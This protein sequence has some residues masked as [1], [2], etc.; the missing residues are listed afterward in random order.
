MQIF[1]RLLNRAILSHLLVAVP[2]AVVLGQMVISI[3][4]SAL[5][6]ETQRLHLSLAAQVRDAIEEEADGSIALLGH[7]ERILDLSET[8]IVQRQDMLRAL[9][10]DGRIPYLTLYRPD[11][12]FDT[13][14]RPKDGPEV[15]RSSLPQDRQDS[16]KDELVAVWDRPARTMVIVP[17]ERDGDL[18]GFVATELPRT[19]LRQLCEALAERHLGTSG[20][21]DVVAIDG[22]Y[23]ASSDP[24]H[25]GLP[26]RATTVF[27][28]VHVKGQGGLTALMAGV[29]GDFKDP[30]GASQLGAVVSSPRLGWLVGASRP[31]SKALASLGRV[32]TRVVLMS[33]IAAL[34]A[35]LVGLLMARQ[36]T[37]PVQALVQSVRRAAQRGFAPDTQIR[38]TGEL[39]QLALAFNQALAQ[40]A[41]Y[42]RQVRQTMQLRLRLSRLATTGSSSARELL[43]RATTAVS[44][45]AAEPMTILYADVMFEESEAAESEYLVTIL[46][47]FFTAAHEAIRQ[48]GGR[49]DRYSGDAVI[50]LFPN[51]S[52]DASVAVAL[53]AAATIRHDAQAI[54]GRWAALSPLRL[55]AS[56]GV[57]SGEAVLV[58]ADEPGQDPTAHGELVE[59]AATLQRR[60]SAGR[61]LLDEPSAKTLDALPESAPEP[62]EPAYVWA[63]TDLG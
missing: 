56:V 49:V 35:G 47:E 40:L 11:G 48:E 13:V 22:R 4:E 21:V 30:A 61:V 29:A 9:V 45:E 17:W 25:E 62:G 12:E 55:H 60:A 63:D 28:M 52:I 50:G 36:I 27:A 7:A 2:P 5:R 41:E 43:A 39:G 42:R 3:N 33:V 58:M 20:L 53:R 31:A 18:L 26:D 51:A 24:G 1:G 32:R 54:T 16:A 14:I 34:V 57:A 23:V 6:T 8:P 59:R 38:G 46:G 15:D 10:A 37:G 19:R 44:L